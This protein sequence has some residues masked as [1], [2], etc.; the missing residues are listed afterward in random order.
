D[1]Q[2]LTGLSH[3]KILNL[4]GPMWNPSAGSSTD[5]SRELRHLAGIRS[6][7]ELTFSYTYL[8]SIKFEDA[9]I[10]AIAPLRPSLRGFSL[11]NTQGGGRHRALLTDVEAVNL[12]YCRVNDEGLRQIQGL[13]SLRRL[14]LRDAVISD[15]GLRSLS[16]LRNVEQLDLGGTRITDAGIAHLQG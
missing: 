4:P 14:L 15:E 13:S 8:E 6:L 3:L 1:L 10:E 12:V 5:Y 2:R 7:E 9:G 16:G 11:E